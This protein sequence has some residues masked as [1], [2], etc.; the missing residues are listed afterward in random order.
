VFEPP[1]ETHTLVVPDGVEEMI[2]YFQ[3]NG[4]MYNVDP[5]GDPV[6]YEDVFTKIDMCRKHFAEVGLGADFVNQFI[7]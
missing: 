7:R 1:S 4:V 6:G 2:T 5:W 3:V